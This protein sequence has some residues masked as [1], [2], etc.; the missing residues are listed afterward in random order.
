MK[1]KKRLI[2]LSFVTLL[3]PG[4][5]YAADLGIGV[6]IDAF[7]DDGI[8]FGVLLPMRF[9]N[10]TIEPE[11]SFSDFSSDG[12]TIAGNEST[13]RTSF[14]VG[15]GIYVR[16][17]LVLFTESYFGVR[18]GYRSDDETTTSVNGADV[19]TYDSTGHA[20]FI[21]PTVGIQYFFSERFS[22]GCDVGLM[23][24]DGKNKYS[25]SQNGVAFGY[26]S[27]DYSEWSTTSRVVVR[28]F[29]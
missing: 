18:L 2:T 24:S 27:G 25:Q 28:A 14:S 19:F 11:G 23:Y 10:L 3:F 13:E 29:F 1:L 8:G 5:L 4:S 17:N 21:A 15:T 26:S 20:L 22:L 12:A 9:G 16:K 6:N 7:S